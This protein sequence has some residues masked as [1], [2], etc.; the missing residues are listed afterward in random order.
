MLE[1]MPKAGEGIALTEEQCDEITRLF[2]EDDDIPKN[3][4]TVAFINGY[5][6][7]IA[8]SSTPKDAETYGYDAFK[9]GKNALFGVITDLNKIKLKRLAQGILDFVKE[10]D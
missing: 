10:D 2:V 6:A 3:L 4:D 1:N 8:F 9:Y 7:G 5:Q